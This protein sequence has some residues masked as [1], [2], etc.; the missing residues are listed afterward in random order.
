MYSLILL[1][2]VFPNNSI[3]LFAIPNLVA[4]AFQSFTVIATSEIIFEAMS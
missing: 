2:K 4:N 3:S 1:I